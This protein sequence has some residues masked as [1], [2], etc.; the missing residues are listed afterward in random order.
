M[1]RV[2]AAAAAGLRPEKKPV[3]FEHTLSHASLAHL[4]VFLPH[5]RR[6]LLHNAPYGSFSLFDISTLDTEE[7]PCRKEGLKTLSLEQ[8]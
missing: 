7:L 5:F 1:V 6:H 3:T 8:F 4:A 2:F